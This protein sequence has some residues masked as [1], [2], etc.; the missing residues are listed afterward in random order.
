MLEKHRNCLKNA[1]TF[2]SMLAG[3]S[4]RGTFP[5]EIVPL[6]IKNIHVQNNY[7]K[8]LISNQKWQKYQFTSG[9]IKILYRIGL[10]Q[11]VILTVLDCICTCVKIDCHCYL[12]CIFLLWMLH[13]MSVAWTKWGKNGIVDNFWLLD[14]AISYENIYKC[15]WEM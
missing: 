4:G 12:L 7:Y 9:F 5:K 3:A 8:K 14:A 2:W 15:N 13:K 11:I 1:V 10:L 6:W